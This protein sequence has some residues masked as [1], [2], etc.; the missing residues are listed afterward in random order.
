MWENTEQN[1]S[2]Y[3]YF[4]RSP[5]VEIQKLQKTVQAEKNG[6]KDAKKLYKL[7]SNALYCKTMEN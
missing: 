4:L 5:Y 3:G 1:N 2:K 7:M 6:D